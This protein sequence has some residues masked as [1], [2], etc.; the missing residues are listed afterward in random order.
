VEDEKEFA[1]EKEVALVY[2]PPEH[3]IILH[4]AEEE[5]GM[6]IENVIDNAIRYAPHGSV[7]VTLQAGH[8]SAQVR[9]EDTGIGIAAED[10]DR[11]FRKFYRAQNALLAQPDGTGIGLYITKKIVEKHGGS[12]S[13]ASELG[14]GTKFLITL[15]LSQK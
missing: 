7:T 12:V 13:F 11:I 3:P 14:K 9:I 4:G 10:R 6:A 1:R 2:N 5:L 8:G 15:P